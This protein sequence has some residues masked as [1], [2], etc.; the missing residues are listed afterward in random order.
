M[1]VVTSP[2]PLLIPYWPIFESPGIN[3]QPERTERPLPK[4]QVSHQAF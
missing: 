4:A 3:D 1:E 2:V